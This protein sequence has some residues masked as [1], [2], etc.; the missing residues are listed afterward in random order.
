[1]PVQYMDAVLILGLFALMCLATL[2]ALELGYWRGMR[3]RQ[4]ADQKGE[5][6]VGGVVGAVLGLA[7]FMMAFA[8]GLAAAR[9][10]SRKDLLLE[11]VNTIATTHLRAGLLLEPHR[12][13]VRKLLRE[14][15]DLRADLPNIVRRPAGLPQALARADEIQT[16][17]W[18]H[19][20]AIAEANR[21]S[22]ID[23]LFIDSLNEMID[24]H[25]K[26]VVFATQYRIP[27]IVWG[28]LAF[29]SLIAMAAVGFHF[30]LNGA[31][32]VFAN[33]ALALTFAAV[34]VLI[35][36]LDLPMHGWLTTSQQ[37]MVELQQK[38]NAQ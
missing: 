8:F 15:V 10:Q 14:Y 29:V 9:F 16:A 18:S 36:D 13:D 7:A 21:S 11:E 5:G 2:A 24:L 22:E 32:S 20:T 17:L 6:P 23:A 27:G 28:V 38:L 34:M 31:R 4:K 3:R 30:G 33:L 26:R 19:A 25:T 1:M 35:V 37:P 12:T